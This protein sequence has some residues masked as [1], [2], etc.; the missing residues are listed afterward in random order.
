MNNSYSRIKK[1]DIIGIAG[2]SLCIVHC[3][4]IPML[5][6]FSFGSGETPGVK[7][8]FILLSFLAI[9]K[10]IE[11]GRNQKLSFFLLSSFAGFLFSSLF[12]EEFGWLHEAGILFSL[13]IITG[14]VISI[15]SCKKCKNEEL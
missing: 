8:F 12:E 13:L 14:H 7:Y 11:R 4:G 1:A 10:S 15:R 6:A 3:L 9:Y 5:T 2:S